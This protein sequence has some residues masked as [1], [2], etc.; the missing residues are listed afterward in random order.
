MQFEPVNLNCLQGPKV[1]IMLETEV[2]IDFPIDLVYAWV[3]GSD[4]EWREKRDRYM[5]ERPKTGPSPQSRSESRWRD[6][7][8]LLY[9]L[10]SVELYAPWVNRIF[11]ITDGQCPKWLNVEHPKVTIIDHSEI[12]PAD[13]LPVFSS[14]AIESCIYKIPGLSEHF[15]FG[16]DDTFFGAPTTPETFFKPDGSPIVRLMGARFN[17]RKARTGSNYMRVLF[18][19]QKL[20]NEMFGKMICHTPHH[21]FDAYRKS[22]FEYCVSLLPD[23]W[24]RTAHRRFRNNKDMQRCFVS[25]Y[26]LATGKGELRKVGRYNR[27]NTPTDLV[28]ALMSG[29]YAADSRW[30]RLVT[31]D[32]DF[33]KYNPLMFCMN[34]S[35]YTSDA[36][37]ERMVNFLKMK[38]PNKSQFE[39]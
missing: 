36:E 29:H 1:I 22:D 26:V 13:A 30:I 3:D 19:M 35:E 20:I 2:R 5:P 4:P 9:S 37:R 18:R 8:E 28:K 32:K 21:N 10:R 11:I 17:R 31:P 38:F 39:K 34:D 23:E 15:I 12:L 27:I 25:Y 16:N 14:H 33:E 6:N 7:D 24:D